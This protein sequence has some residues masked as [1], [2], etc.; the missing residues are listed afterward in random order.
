MLDQNIKDKITDSLNAMK[1][2]SLSEMENVELLNR[3]D[4]KYMIHI[5]RLIEILAL[6]KNDYRILEVKGVRLNRYNNLYFDTPDYNFYL[7][8]HN[9]KANRLKIRCRSYVDSNVSFFEVKKKN[10]KDKTEKSRISTEGISENINDQQEQLI[11]QIAPSLNPKLLFPIQ[12]NDF[13]RMTL[14]NIQTMERATID[15]DLAFYRN[16]S[17]HKIEL[18][19]LVIVEVKQDV[20]SGISPIRRKLKEEKIYATSISKYIL[21]E[22]LL[23][24]ELKRNNFKSKLLTLNKIEHE[25]VA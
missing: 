10:N 24:K 2:I 9:K 16:G 7:T 20:H 13:F 21:G 3:F 23:N 25:L 15:I 6:I 8:H 1:P 19:N 11:K 14:V 12:R 22:L 5:D 18:P 17:T 4:T